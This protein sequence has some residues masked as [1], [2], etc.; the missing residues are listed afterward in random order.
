MPSPWLP[1]PSPGVKEGVG[2]CLQEVVGMEQRSPRGAG[3]CWGSWDLGCCLVGCTLPSFMV[4]DRSS[5]SEPRS[6]PLP[7]GKGNG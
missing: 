1:M 3:L 2:L 4:P 6:S 5:P 7:R